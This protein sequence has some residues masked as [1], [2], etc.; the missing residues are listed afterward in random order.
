[1]KRS[2]LGLGFWPETYIRK[3]GK[4]GSLRLLRRRRAKEFSILMLIFLTCALF[5]VW[6]RI[7]V[8]R[9][10]YEIANLMKDRERLLE[11]QKALQIEVA[12]LKSPVRLEDIAKN[13][14]H[15]ARP[16]SHQIIFVSEE[17]P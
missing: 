7:G 5:F 8:V 16:E 6:S 13:D 14:F 1:M 3:K 15:M 10:G 12:T 9:H 11:T 2:T 17:Q 4:V